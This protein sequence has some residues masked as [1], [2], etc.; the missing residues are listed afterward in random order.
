MIT[1]GL[2]GGE[3]PAG[4]TG[5]VSTRRCGLGARLGTTKISM[6]LA[7]SARYEF[8]GL[9]SSGLLR[10]LASIMSSPKCA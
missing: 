2:V 6:D 7:P 1:Q 9:W 8:G 5:P 10:L 4:A 3:P